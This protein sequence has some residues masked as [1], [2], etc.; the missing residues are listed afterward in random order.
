MILPQH[1][2]ELGARR[3]PYDGANR[4]ASDASCAES[5]A[6]PDST[7][8]PTP[9]KP[10][11]RPETLPT[12]RPLLC[13]DTETTGLSTPCI[14]QL[15]YVFVAVDGSVSETNKILKLPIGVSMHP[16]VVK[17]H[18]VTKMMCDK[19]CDP[20]IELSIFWNIVNA[21]LDSGGC[22]IGHN[23]SFD[24]RAFNT[25][26]RLWNMDIVLDRARMTDTMSISKHLSTLR[27]KDGRRSKAFKNEELYEYLFHE[28]PTAWGA[29]MHNALDDVYVTLLNFQHGRSRALF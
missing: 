13:F 1:F 29:T 3:T 9:C 17:I 12:D 7:R 8:S 28:S 16:D 6:Q 27:T 25:T 20:T 14:C 19:G 4:H 23:V 15:A 24:V 22:V 11:R 10:G 18:G 21:T 26:C 2:F 5:N